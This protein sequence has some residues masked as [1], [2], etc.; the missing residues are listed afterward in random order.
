METFS[1]DFL[2]LVERQVVKIK[3]DTNE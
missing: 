2:S 1:S 3:K